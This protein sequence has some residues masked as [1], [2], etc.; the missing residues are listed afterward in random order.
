VSLEEALH[1]LDAGFL[2]VFMTSKGLFVTCFAGLEQV[3]ITLYC[4]D[5]KR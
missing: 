4:G 3:I 1:Q 5:C 2:F